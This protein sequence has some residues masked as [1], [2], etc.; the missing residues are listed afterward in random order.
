MEYQAHFACKRPKVGGV[1]NVRLISLK[2]MRAPPAHASLSALHLVHYQKLN[3]CK[4]F[5]FL[6]KNSIFASS[7]KATNC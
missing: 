4:N 2:G 6:P 3:S 1:S 7:L 5:Y